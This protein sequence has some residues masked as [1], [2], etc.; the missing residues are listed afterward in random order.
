LE[1][2]WFCMSGTDLDC[3]YPEGRIPLDSR[4]R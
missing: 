4:R 3:N 1:L 2:L